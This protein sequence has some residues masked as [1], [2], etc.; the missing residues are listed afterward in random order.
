MLILNDVQS[1]LN[2]SY[3]SGELCPTSIEEISEGVMYARQK[4]I[5][6][7]PAGSLHSMGGQQF[8]AGGVLLNSKNLK[9]IGE[10]NEASSTVWVQSGVVWTELVTWLKSVQKDIPNKLSIIQKQTGADKL[11]IGG[12]IASNIHG[13]VLNKKPI[14]DDI[15]SFHITTAQGERILCSRSQNRELFGLVIGGYG[16]L[17]FVD[18]IEL[19]LVK[20]KVLVRH[21]QELSVSEVMSA[22][23]ESIDNGAIYGDFQYMTDESSPEFLEKGIMSVYSPSRD[24]VEIPKNQIGLSNEDWMKF[25]EL[26]HTN[27]KEAY[28]AYVDHYL[29]TDTQLYWSDDQQFSPYL[30]EAGTQLVQAMGWTNY[31]SLMITELY[32]PRNNFES[33]MK[34]AKAS[35]IDNGANVVYGTVRLIESEDE[36]ELRWARKNYACVIF[37]LLVEHTGDG[38]N[39]AIN[40]FRSLIDCA[41]N[42]SGSYYLTYHRWATKNQIEEAYPNFRDFL[43]LKEHYDEDAIFDSDWHRHY[44]EMFK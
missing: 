14:I 19:S 18:S 5:S 35:L 17:G 34:S 1:K 30:P 44:V 33:F 10:L 2:Q 42:Q 26:A 23:Q 27:K 22:L 9:K 11:T 13:R 8:L 43:A 12:A 7:C 31:V 15:K 28:K 21:V 3:M 36:S 6:L 29:Q 32:V 40:Q 25:Y 20:R 39:K 16:L 24:F 37:N 4:G 38:I 41:L